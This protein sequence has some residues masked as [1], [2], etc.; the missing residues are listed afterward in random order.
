MLRDHSSKPEVRIKHGKNQ[1]VSATL[2]TLFFF[3]CKH[4][5]PAEVTEK[6]VNYSWNGQVPNLK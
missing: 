4:H 1:Q 2:A 5:Q 3:H 6:I